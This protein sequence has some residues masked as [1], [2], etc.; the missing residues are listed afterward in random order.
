ME[1]VKKGDIY[2]NDQFTGIL[3]HGISCAGIASEELDEFVA[4]KNEKSN[5]RSC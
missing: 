4:F 5:D 2:D 1:E 3:Q